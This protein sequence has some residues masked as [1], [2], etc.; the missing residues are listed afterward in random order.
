[1]KGVNHSTAFRPVTLGTGGP[2]LYNV[3]SSSNCP[4]KRMAK[5]PFIETRGCQMNEHDSSRMTGLLGEHQALKVTEG[6]AEADIIL[7]STYSIRERA[8]ERVS[9][10]LGMWHELKQQNPDLAV[11]IDGCA[12][13]QEGATVRERA[14]YVDVVFGP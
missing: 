5:R 10:K 14:P 6:A 9:S 3:Q 2:A 1:M 11:G 13:S 7:L 4:A 8:Q 12:A